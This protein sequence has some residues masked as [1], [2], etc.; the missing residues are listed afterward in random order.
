MTTQISIHGLK[1]YNNQGQEID[2]SETKSTLIQITE[3]KFI[4]YH[5]TELNTIKK[6][7]GKFAFVFAKSSESVYQSLILNHATCKR[8][9]NFDKALKIAN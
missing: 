9:E 4:N 3:D 1:F 5:G 8:V 7:G 6:L 2:F